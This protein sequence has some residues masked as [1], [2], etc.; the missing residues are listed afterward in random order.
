MKSLPLVPAELAKVGVLANQWDLHLSRRACSHPLRFFR[1]EPYHI[2]RS[3][4][5]MQ[6]LILVPAELSWPKL[7]SGRSTPRGDACSLLAL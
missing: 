4:H 3:E 1:G 5:V 2:I 6:S 7:A